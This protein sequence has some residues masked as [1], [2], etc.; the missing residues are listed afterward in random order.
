LLGVQAVADE[1]GEINPSAAVAIRFR[2]T[3]NEL[4]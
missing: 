2:M 1:A 4:E 3:V